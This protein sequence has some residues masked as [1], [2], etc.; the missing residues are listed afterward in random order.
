MFYDYP[1]DFNTAGLDTQYLFGKELMVIPVLNED[2]T[3]RIYLP[4]GQWTDFYD[5]GIVEGGKWLEQVVPLDKIPGITNLVMKRLKFDEQ[6]ID[7]VV[8]L[9]KYHDADLHEKRRSIRTW[10]DPVQWRRRKRPLLHRSQ[11]RKSPA[12]WPWLK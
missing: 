3:V 4:Q 2:N 7:T 9:V 1:T 11:D 6:T 5:D 10:L 8:E 12:C